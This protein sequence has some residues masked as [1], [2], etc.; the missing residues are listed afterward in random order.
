MDIRVCCGGGDGQELRKSCLR[1]EYFTWNL[2]H[3]YEITM[4]VGGYRTFQKEAASGKM[5][6][7]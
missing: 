6:I 1:K 7:K 5:S 4:R 3:E 2:S